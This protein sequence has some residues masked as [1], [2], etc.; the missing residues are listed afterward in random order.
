MS[1]AMLCN[2]E[3]TPVSSALQVSGNTSH[4]NFADVWGSRS[5]G[6]GRSLATKKSK[7]KSQQ[8]TH[9]QDISGMICSLLLSLA[10]IA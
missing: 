7:A 3:L 10:W 2:E 9:K 4:N 5:S 8:D 6:E 1:T